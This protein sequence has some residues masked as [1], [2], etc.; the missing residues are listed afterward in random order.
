MH[1]LLKWP[2]NE[3]YTV[4]G[5]LKRRRSYSSKPW[6]TGEIKDRWPIS[7]AAG[8]DVQGYRGVSLYVKLYSGRALRLRSEKFGNPKCNNEAVKIIGHRRCLLPLG[9]IKT[10]SWW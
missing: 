8:G 10:P 7:A 2:S 3:G 6:F 1:F 9:R 5:I 4:R